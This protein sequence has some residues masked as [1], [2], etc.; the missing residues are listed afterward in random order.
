MKDNLLIPFSIGHCA[1]DLV[2]IAMYIIIPAFGTAM[3]LSP[4]KIGLL[5][6]I[7]NLSAIAYFPA[8]LMAD[9]SPNRGVLLTATFFWVGVGY[10]IASFADHFW[11]FAILIA[12][13]AMGDA[14]WHPLATAVLTQMNKSRRAFALGM[15]A[16]GGNISEVI[17]L[18]AAGFFIMLWDWKTAIQLMVLPTLLM[19]C[20][21]I[22]IAPK[23]PR[24]LNSQFTRSDF[25]QIWNTWKTVTGIRVIA[26]FTAYNMALFAITTMTPLYLRSNHGFD[27]MMTALLLAVMMLPGA[28][29]QP[30]V[31]KV[32]DRVGRRPLILLGN[33]VAAGAALA[34]GLSLSFTL[35]LAGLGLALT[36]LVS[37]RPVLLAAAVDHSAGREGASLGLT[38]AFMDGFAA[39]SAVLAGLVGEKDLSN[40][41]LLASGFSLI[42]V[43]LA[44]AI[45]RGR[46]PD[47][48]PVPE[49]AR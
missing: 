25:T 23:V 37:I 35:A 13:A 26:L 8:G 27:W 9:H 32:S 4:A 12:V 28:L 7:H 33:S 17:A 49:I 45:P 47:E 40:A 41:F 10:F 39:S 22:F 3:G 21:F 46:H 43:V 20:V 34:A 29:L 19:G 6:M 1:N 2:P 30:W 5:F 24:N 11:M 42:A 18:P 31:G 38:F 15:H 36:V 44:L 48:G 16:I 14:F